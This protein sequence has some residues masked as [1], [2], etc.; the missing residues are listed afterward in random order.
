MLL[1]NKKKEKLSWENGKLTGRK[2]DRAGETPC[3]CRAHPQRKPLQKKE[4]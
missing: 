3:T 2:R 1:D 4:K